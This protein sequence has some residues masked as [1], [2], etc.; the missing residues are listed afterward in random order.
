[1]NKSGSSWM[2]RYDICDLSQLNSGLGLGAVV[3]V[4]VRGCWGSEGEEDSSDGHAWVAAWR[5]WLVSCRQRGIRASAVSGEGMHNQTLRC[6]WCGCSRRPDL[7]V[8]LVWM[9][10]DL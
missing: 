7:A 2:G 5:R 4:Q 10:Q 1:M 8:C 9:Q 6:V 3:E